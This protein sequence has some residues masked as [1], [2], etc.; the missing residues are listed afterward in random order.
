MKQKI[1]VRTRKGKTIT[2][3]ATVT[4]WIGDNG[5]RSATAYVGRA[6]YVIAGRDYDGPIW[7][8]ESTVRMFGKLG[9]M[10]AKV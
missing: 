3:L 5:Q 7:A 2:R 9:D 6:T 1:R 10:R 8:A 4:D